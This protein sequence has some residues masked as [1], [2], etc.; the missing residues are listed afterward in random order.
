MDKILAEFEPLFEAAK[1]LL[2]ADPA[3]EQAVILKTETGNIC[4]CVSHAIRSGDTG[5]EDQLAAELRARGDT[6]VRCL[7]AMWQ[8][9]S[10]DLPSCNLREQLLSLDEGNGPCP[11]LLQGEAGYVLRPLAFTLGRG[12]S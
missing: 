11:I 6:R 5:A 3:A 9:G 1:N 4:H 7:L 8:G 2:Q 12:E 10:V